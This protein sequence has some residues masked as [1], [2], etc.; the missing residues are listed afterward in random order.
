MITRATA[1]KLPKQGLLHT[2]MDLDE[3]LAA[4]QDDNIST[5]DD[6][7]QNLHLLAKTVKEQNTKLADTNT[8]HK[9]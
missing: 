5:F 7:K 3:T 8:N 9:N 1:A 2:K 4:V 6:V